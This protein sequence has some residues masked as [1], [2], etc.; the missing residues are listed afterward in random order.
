M[1][2][3]PLN[4]LRAYALVFAEGGI[5]PAARSLGISHSSVSRHLHELE[6][7]LETD[8]TD[9]SEGGRSLSFSAQGTLLGEAALQCF[10]DLE[11]AANRVRERR[12]NTT[13]VVDT[14]PSVAARWLLPR[15][16]AFEDVAPRIKVS[17]V[18]DQ[19]QRD[20]V[21]CGYDLSIRM[22]GQPDQTHEAVPLMSDRL[23]PVASP[24]Y[25]ERHGTPNAV[26]DLRNHVLLHDRDPKASWGTWAKQFDSVPKGLKDGQRF[27]SS[28]LVI[29][30]AEQ[31]LGVALARMRLAEDSLREGR[32]IA[33]L[34]DTSLELPSAYWLIFG[35]RKERRT[36]QKFVDWLRTEAASQ[37]TTASELTGP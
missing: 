3:L 7:W 31:G 25:L 14:T 11:V 12:D 9:R 19:R 2:D 26:Q 15:L 34:K 29:R 16:V 20:P 28:D 33:L 37:D 32:L 21:R 30:A 36:V 35:Q 23:V 6:A 5:R 18:V 10:L 4:A 1:R 17:I 24:R 13:V 27:G 22:G 8:L